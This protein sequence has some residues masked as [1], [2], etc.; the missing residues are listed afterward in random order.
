L[1]NERG[2]TLLELVIAIMITALILGTLYLFF[3]FLNREG[4]SQINEQILA[5]RI[6]LFLSAISKDFRTAKRVQLIDSNQITIETVDG[7]VNT[8]KFLDDRILK[9]GTEVV[10]KLVSTAFSLE[11]RSPSGNIPY[12]Y[13]SKLNISLSTSTKEFKISVMRRNPP[14]G[15]E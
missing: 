6:N 4:K 14:E 5:D 2:A 8:Y 1:G 13:Y 15:N 9:N 3:G 12:S 7:R 10:S 11:K